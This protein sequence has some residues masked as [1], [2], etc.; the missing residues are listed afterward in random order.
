M[1]SASPRRSDLLKQIGLPFEVRVS[2]MEEVTSKKL[3]H[4]IVMELSLQKAEAVSKG[5]KEDVVIIGADTIVALNNETMGKPKTVEHAKLML[6]SL[7]GKEHSVY[8]GVTLLKRE[9]E[10][11]KINTFYAQTKV[12]MYPM[13]KEEVKR[14]AETGEPLDK[15]GGYAIQGR[16]AAF[17]K[18]IKGD[19]NNVV[20]LPV[21]MVYQE[22]KKMVLI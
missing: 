13:T 7:Q 11:K 21:G 10:R 16:C 12:V 3:P 1:A 22:L 9:R 18:E 15:A 6:R 20:G 14:Y 2:G 17:I 5:L 8:T 19:Y 4:E